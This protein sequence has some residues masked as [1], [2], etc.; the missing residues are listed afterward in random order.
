MAGDTWNKLNRLAA[1]QSCARPTEYRG[2]VRNRPRKFLLPH[3][4]QIPLAIFKIDIS[5]IADIDPEEEA[6][7]FMR[8]FPT[9]GRNLRLSI[10]A[11]GVEREADNFVRIGAGRAATLRP[12]GCPRNRRSTP[13]GA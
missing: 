2:S 7:K 11:E 12:L 4:R 3:L 1:R 13:S 9:L 10:T 6:E 5:V 8:A